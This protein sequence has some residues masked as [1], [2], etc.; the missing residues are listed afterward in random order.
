MPR[1]PARKRAA[2]RR[3]DICGDAITMRRAYVEI[4]P[5]APIP[6]GRYE[7]EA[8]LESASTIL[9]QLDR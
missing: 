8:L 7:P 9:E 3:A 1:I 2:A 4:R 6:P 5:L